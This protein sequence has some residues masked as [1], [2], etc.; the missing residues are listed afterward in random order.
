VQGKVTGAVFVGDGNFV[1]APPGSELGMLKLLTKEN[2]FSENFTH[3]VLRFTDSTDEEIK[4]ASSSAS[5]G[6]DGGLLKDSQNA[7]RHGRTLKHTGGSH[8]A[9]CAQPRAGWAVRGICTWKALQRQRD[10][11]CRSARGEIR[12]GGRSWTDDV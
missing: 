3:L 7:M 6:C 10:F 8:P 11:C 12:D 2:E 4:K 1:I 9:G 5:G